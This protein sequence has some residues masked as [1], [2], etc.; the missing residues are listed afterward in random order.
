M[1]AVRLRCSLWAAQFQL[2]GTA[3]IVSGSRSRSRKADP[4]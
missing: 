3:F 4:R 1:R 2:I